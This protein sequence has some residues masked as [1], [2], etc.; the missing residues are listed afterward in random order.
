[1]STNRTLFT[2]ATTADFGE[3][4]ASDAVTFIVQGT[5]VA[6]E[7]IDVQIW[8]G[9]AFVDLYQDGTQVQ[10]SS[11]NIAVTAYGPGLYRINKGTTTNAITVVA[12]TKRDLG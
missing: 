2:A 6:S 10:L 9:I 5:Q 3:F 7:P 11:V 12:V 8:T 1:M 4:T